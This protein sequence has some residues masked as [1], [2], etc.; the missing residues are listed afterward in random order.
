MIDTSEKDFEASIE[1]GLIAGE[2]AKRNPD[3]FNKELGLDPGPLFDFIYSSQPQTWEN[4]KKQHGDLQVK[5]RF[6]AR[7]VKEIQKP[8]M[9]VF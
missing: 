4:L 1:A 8:L 3:Q 9:P 6:L 5:E 7:L 2:Y